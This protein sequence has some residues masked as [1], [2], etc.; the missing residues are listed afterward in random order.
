MEW[1]KLFSVYVFGKGIIYRV[2]M[3]SQN[4]IVGSKNLIKKMS[5]KFEQMYYQWRYDQH[6]YL[7]GQNRWQPH[8]QREC[9]M[10]QPFWKA[11]S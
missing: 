10:E 11:I 6:Y 8:W 1:N 2:Y 4:S 7:L 3:N 9:E 5:K